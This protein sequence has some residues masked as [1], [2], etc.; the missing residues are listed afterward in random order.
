MWLVS[1]IL[2]KLAVT[3]NPT[4]KDLDEGDRVHEDHDEVA[5]HDCSVIQFSCG[6][7]VTSCV[8]AFFVLLQSF[9][10][11]DT[12]EYSSMLTCELQART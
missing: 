5:L 11:V 9:H 6:Q 10:N 7:Q 1:R 12:L 8:L 4:M 2:A 3:K